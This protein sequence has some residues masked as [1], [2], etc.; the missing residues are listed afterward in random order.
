MWDKISGFIIRFRLPLI[1]LIGLVTV[2]MGYFAS[3]VEMSYDLARTVPADDPDQ[4]FLQEFKKQFGEDANIIGIGVLD[5]TIYTL[6]KF[7]RFRDLNKIVKNITGVNNVLSLPEV[8]IIRKDTA[9]K[10]FK[11]EPLF[12]KAMTS[13]QELDSLMGE[14]RKQKF[15]MGQLVSEKNGA[16]LMLISIQKEFMNSAKRVELMQQLVEAGSAFEKFTNIKLHYAGL[17]FI[18]TKM[19]SQVRQEMQFFLY[20][21]ALVT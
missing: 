6:D 11:L 7:N 9:H 2:V 1:I 20:L 10:K 14:L 18:R 5:S 16:T 17:P 21:S 12:P 19:A 4:V 3:K 15:Y 13:Q 8:K